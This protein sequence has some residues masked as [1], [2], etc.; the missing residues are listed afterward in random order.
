MRTERRP[1]VCIG[2]SHIEAVVAAAAKASIPL[3][4][5]NFW[6]LG[7][8]IDRSSGVVEL[9]AELRAR[10]VAPVFSFVGGGVHQDFGLVVH[11]RPYDFIWPQEPDLPL[12]NGAEMVPF[13]ALHTSMRTR[14]QPYLDI[15]QAIRRATEGP[16]FH[17]EAPPP[18][19]QETVPADD[20]A[21]I[22]YF[23]KDSAIS[24]A[25]LRYKLWKVHSSL[26]KAYCQ[27]ADIV[28]VPHP[29]EA[30]DARGFL[31]TAY[32]GSPAHANA[33]YGALVLRQMLD[34]SD[35]MGPA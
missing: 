9:T 1:L 20:P 3:E 34:L 26:V 18:Y 19:E 10:L 35:S 27:G 7:S 22:V 17:M 5:L 16:V 31:A 15:M 24:P 13:D 14:T 28:F 12:S 2:H 21:W 6:H 11:P 4:G 23:G 32:R 33:E 25:W 29:P 8:P 30:I